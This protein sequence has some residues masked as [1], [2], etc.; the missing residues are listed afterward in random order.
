MKTYRQM[1]EEAAAVTGGQYKGYSLGNAL[2]LYVDEK[3]GVNAAASIS[4]KDALVDAL[5]P[6]LHDSCEY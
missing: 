5:Q 1:Y 4:A 3:Y 6:L 2:S